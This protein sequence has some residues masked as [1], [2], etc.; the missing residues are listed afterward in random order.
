MEEIWKQV[1]E[2]PVYYVSNMG[3]VK[4]VDHPVW[5]KVNNSYS[6]RKGRFC[7]P[8][9]NNSK[10]YW[11]VGIQINGKQKHFA[12]HRLVAKAF[13]PNPD[14]LPQ[15]NHIDGNKNN[16]CVSNL[17]WCTNEYNRQH[18]IENNLMLSEKHKAKSSEC[19]N[20]RKLTYEQI[21]FI[22][23]EYKNTSFNKRGELVQFYKE[24]AELFNL[25]SISTVLWVIN[26]G[27]NNYINQDIV[28]TTNFETW[29]RKKDIIHKKYLEN[30]KK[31]LK[32]YAQELG[33]NEK[34]FSSMYRKFNKNLDK[35]ISFYKEKGGENHSSKENSKT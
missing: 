34:A 35:T 23:E 14:N 4:T 15:I 9:N 19:C 5:C 18:A 31:L 26:E 20:F 13:I 8:T 30:K 28:Q 24:I 6:I 21:L 32:D 33:V 22:R 12:I 17:E 10:G 27:T 2:N 3:R 7:V 29:K 25:N 11:R 16:N 1:E